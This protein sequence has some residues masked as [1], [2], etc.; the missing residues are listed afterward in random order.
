MIARFSLRARL[1][2]VAVAVTLAA[3]VAADFVVY[4]EFRSY[5]FSRVDSTLENAHPGLESV[6]N[7]LNG[8]TTGSGR[9]AN[10]VQSDEGTQPNEPGIDS[11]FCQ[12]GATSAPGM[13]I[14]VRTSRGQVVSGDDGREV[15]KAFEIGEQLS[16][17]KIPTKITGFHTT[18][19]NR[20]ELVTYFSASSQ[21]GGGE[22]YR[23]RVS[24]LKNGD[25]LV[26]ADPVGDVANSIHRLILLEVLVT[27]VAFLSA[28]IISLGLIRIGL[29]PLRDVERTADAITGGDLVHRVPNPNPRTEVGHVATALNVMLD[30]IQDTFEDL[31][32]SEARLRRFVSDASHELR[33]P[34][35]AVSAYAELY[36]R[37]AAAE[38]ADLARV[39]SGI[40]RESQRMARL[41]EDLLTLARLDE[42]VSIAHEPV[43]LVGLAHEAIETAGTVGP[44]W[45][46]D[47]QAGEVVE[48]FG[49]HDALRR[50]IDNL[51]S[52]VRS[53]TPEGTHATLS[54]RREGDEAIIEL[55]DE[56]PGISDEDART[57]FERFVRVDPS[58][59]RTTGGAGLGLAI[60]ASVARAHGG[61]AEAKPREHGGAIFR[62]LLPIFEDS[63]KK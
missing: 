38:Q 1:T 2:F 16:Q 27:S 36:R 46:V 61:R 29:H 10:G 26:I 57:I 47:L 50:V 11:M 21:S 44:G 48:V 31:K 37:G 56:G 6:A 41:V 22:S 20:S 3:L 7:Q 19:D 5:L 54:V 52:N 33:T 15:C 17:P 39:L 4:T 51:L 28:L 8:S 63:E 62:V 58:R 32:A 24:L 40:E 43:E 12:I 60:V 55:A 53:H 34:I 9:G 35:A 14:E 49:D 42:H 30:R 23:V 13:F 59:A 45:P 18:P 25:Y